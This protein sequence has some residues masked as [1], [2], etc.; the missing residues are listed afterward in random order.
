MY[1]DISES[2]LVPIQNDL[3]FAL[4]FFL[5]I[6]FILIIARRSLLYSEIFNTAIILDKPTEQFVYAYTIDRKITLRSL[7]GGTFYYSVLILYS[8]LQ[9]YVKI[10]SFSMRPI[11]QL[12]P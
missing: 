12:N 5:F 3:T 6:Q 4:D 8:I 9:M 11:S 7:S 2:G 1:N 10:Y